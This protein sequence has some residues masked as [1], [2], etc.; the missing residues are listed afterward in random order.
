[1]HCGA[2]LPRPPSGRRMGGS[3]TGLRPL[4]FT[5]GHDHKLLRSGEGRAEPPS[6]QATAMTANEG[7]YGRGFTAIELEATSSGRGWNGA[8]DGGILEPGA[9]GLRGR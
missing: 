4:P 5:C 8:A 6:A 2:P 3:S 7:Q 9:R 1:M